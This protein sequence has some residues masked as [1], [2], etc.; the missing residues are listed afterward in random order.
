MS[1][2]AFGGFAF[3]LFARGVGAGLVLILRAL[4]LL[5]ARLILLGGALLIDLL[6]TRV[7]RRLWR[8]LR[9]TIRIRRRRI[10]CRS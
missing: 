1:A 9:A 10:I 3:H 4:R 6:L 8:F 2:A 7:L 5:G